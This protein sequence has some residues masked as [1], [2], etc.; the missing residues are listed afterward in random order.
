M[1]RVISK[2][3]VLKSEWNKII[4]SEV[5]DREYAFGNYVY[6]DI[7]DRLYDLVAI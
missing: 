7:L 4:L 3:L 5:E 2:T 6:F 1:C